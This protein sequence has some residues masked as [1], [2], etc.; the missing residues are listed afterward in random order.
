MSISSPSTLTLFRLK[1]CS[2]LIISSVPISWFCL[3][4]IAAII[5]QITHIINYGLFRLDFFDGQKHLSLNVSAK[6]NPMMAANWYLNVL[7]R[8][9]EVGTLPNVVIEFRVD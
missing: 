2:E 3:S 4:D 9:F 6:Y 5:M 8:S 1:P 7:F